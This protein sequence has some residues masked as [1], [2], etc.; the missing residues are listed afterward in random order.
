MWGVTCRPDQPAARLPTIV[1]W[2]DSAVGLATE[3]SE[4]LACTDADRAGR[5]HTRR[6]EGVTFVPGKHPTLG[7]MHIRYSARSPSPVAANA[8]ARQALGSR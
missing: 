5:H 7:I 6:I 2:L 3:R 4:A 8:D 1:R